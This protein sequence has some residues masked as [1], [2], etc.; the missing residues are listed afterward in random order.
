LQETLD[1][2]QKKQRAENKKKS[3]WP[4]NQIFPHN[5][6]YFCEQNITRSLPSPNSSH[7]ITP[8]ED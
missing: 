8:I 3:S 5:F 7:S 1:F 4:W 6:R 2:S